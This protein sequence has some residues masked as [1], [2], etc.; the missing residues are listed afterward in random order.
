V[1]L[2]VP[3]DETVKRWAKDAGKPAD[4]A[5]LAD[6]AAFA[7]FLGQVMERI[8][9]TL[10]PV[11]RVRRFHIAPAPFTIAGGEMT[12]T[13]KLRRHVIGEKFGP[14]LESLYR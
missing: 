11:E 8:N 10:S 7:A 2:I 4:L 12:P 13:L 1:A 3:D 9:A 14:A 6:D 5:V